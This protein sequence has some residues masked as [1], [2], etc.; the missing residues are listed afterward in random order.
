[1]NPFIWG[2]VL[3]LSRGPR[4][5]RGYS[6]AAEW[7]IE[8]EGHPIASFHIVLAMHN[9]GLIPASSVNKPLRSWATGTFRLDPVLSLRYLALIRERDVKISEVAELVLAVEDGT[10]IFESRVKSGLRTPSEQRLRD[11]EHPDIW[12]DSEGEDDD[13][14]LEAPIAQVFPPSDQHE[15]LL[16]AGK[17]AE[18]S[19]RYASAFK[20]L[21]LA[22]EHNRLIDLE[23]RELAQY[24]KGY[25]RDDTV[26]DG[27]DVFDGLQA[28]AAA[29]TDW[30]SGERLMVS[31][32]KL[33]ALHVLVDLAWARNLLQSDK[34]E[35]AALQI[36]RL[37]IFP[38]SHD[39]VPEYAR[40]FRSASEV[41]RSV[42]PTALQ[43]AVRA[44]AETSQKLSG[45]PRQTEAQLALRAKTQ[46]LVELSRLMNFSS[47]IQ[48]RVMDG[49]RSV[50][51]F[52]LSGS[53][54]V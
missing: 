2:E 12:S 13:G 40:R 46:I 4:D 15:I 16:E 11:V 5:G 10:T 22:G 26:A 47:E 42:Y 50:S 35:Q 24:V 52:P 38:V 49:A 34:F 20:L 51:L 53:D 29:V 7:F 32:D 1:V 14:G 17:K 44:Y 27:L 45:F 41:I 36:E 48:L 23:C 8:R 39:R 9:A 6:D 25:R 33:E 31:R 19:L 30:S 21:R 37:D 18:Q 43:M 54:L 28:R 3:L